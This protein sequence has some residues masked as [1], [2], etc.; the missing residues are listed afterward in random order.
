MSTPINDRFMVL[1]TEYR[2]INCTP[3]VAM[4]NALKGATAL[5]VELSE[6]NAE[7]LRTLS[8]ALRAW[9]LVPCPAPTNAYF[10]LVD[11]TKELVEKVE[12]LL[13]GT[14]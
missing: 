7:Y 13:H 3:E 1:Y 6:K 4:L 10:S 9:L 2:S 14:N 5:E 12:E 8:K 11:A